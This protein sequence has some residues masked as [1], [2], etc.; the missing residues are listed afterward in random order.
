MYPTGNMCE[1]S[2]VVSNSVEGDPCLWA[3]IL[4][5]TETVGEILKTFVHIIPYHQL[6]KE[7]LFSTEEKLVVNMIADIGDP[8]QTEHN[9]A[10]ESENNEW[11]YKSVHRNNLLNIKFTVLAE[12]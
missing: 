1:V 7:K 3:D 12:I 6:S 10:A 9:V 11:Y 8:L 4:V 5:H 2:D